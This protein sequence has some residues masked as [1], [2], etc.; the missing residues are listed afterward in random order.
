MLTSREPKCTE[1]TNGS[2]S[3]VQSK[4]LLKSGLQQH[5]IAEGSELME[6]LL[7]KH[8]IGNPLYISELCGELARQGGTLGTDSE[9]VLKKAKVLPND[10]PRLVFLVCIN[11]QCAR[12]CEFYQISV[13]S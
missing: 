9:R 11:V 3:L 4:L 1:L 8:G 10:L 2:P 6:V 13:T 5:N 12:F 7:N